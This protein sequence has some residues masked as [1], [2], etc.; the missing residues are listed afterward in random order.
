MTTGP[1]PLLS[2]YPTIWLVY[3][4]VYGEI[5]AKSHL[6]AQSNV[7]ASKM[8]TITATIHWNGLGNS[9]FRPDLVCGGL[10]MDGRWATYYSKRKNPGERPLGFASFYLNAVTL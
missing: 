10:K 2:D 4:A 8:H 6:F 1:I 9:G 5:C 7:T 3:S